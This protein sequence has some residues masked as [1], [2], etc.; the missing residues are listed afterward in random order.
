MKPIPT[1]A[2]A[3]C[4]ALAACADLSTPSASPRAADGPRLQ[5]APG[6][7]LSGS[8][9][10]SAG[11]RSYK[12]Y[13][14]TGYR[15]GTPAALVVMLHGCTQDPDQF[16]NGTEMTS[17]GEANGFLVV[18]PD[19][20][21][22]ANQNKCW[23]WF[24]PAHQSRGAGEPSLIAGIVGKLEGEY[25][26][27][28]GRVYVAG[29][30]GGAAMAVIMGVTYP[31]VF[32]AIGVASGLE[33]KAATSTG[34]AFTAMGSAGGP[35]PATQGL[36]AYNAMGS[37]RQTV[38]TIVFHGSSDFTV[39]PING[40]QVANQMQQTNDYVDDG[41]DNNSV[42]SIPDQ[43]VTGTVSGGRAWTRYVY[44]DAAG[45]PLTEK[46]IVTS[47][48]HAWSGGNSAGSYTD[49]Q[50]PKA[51][52]EMW[53]FFSAG[54]GGGDVTPPVLT[55]SP[56]GGSYAD[57]VRVMLS[58][59]EP[60]AI[61]YTTDGS[62]PR[63][64]GTRASMA[65]GGTRTFRATAMLRAYGADAAGNTS[66]TQQHTYTITTSGGGDVTA[67]TLT[68]TPAAG[69]Y[70]D[71]VLVSMSLNEAGTIWYTTDGSNP[72]T[73]G[74]RASFATSGAL[75]LRAS[76]TV[77]AYGVDAAG[78]ASAVQARAYT[79]T[80]TA[81]EQTAT[82]VSVGTEDGYAQ[83]GTSTSTTGSTFSAGSSV[84][85]GEN[86]DRAQRGVLSFNTSSLP[87]GA[88]I[89]SVEVRLFYSQTPFGSAWTTLG[90]L[91][92]DV[93]G[94]CLGASC[95]LAASDW[96]AAAAASGAVTFA[97]PAATTIGTQVTGTMATAGLGQINRTGTTQLRVRFSTHRDA[98]G[99]SDYVVFAGGDFTT[100]GYR[101]VLVVRYR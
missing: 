9:S 45:Q 24:E 15:A 93:Q 6:Q 19:Q 85:V 75:T 60:G 40:H 44:H 31:D 34:S 41:A 65:S 95:A 99:M 13:V 92:G 87:D 56:A 72:A 18:F 97:R 66:A 1:L 83:T 58:I 27:D 7:W 94:G 17:V 32:D 16:A 101:P 57:S 39:Y 22:S 25:T 51:S 64:S 43:T 78:N 12:L 11:T 26:I 53:R 96:E 90:S 98:D 33:Y 84:Y 88:V 5:T 86:L 76:A 89:T 59:D 79:V 38:R 20:P 10:N 77:S 2:L 14:P 81:P 3:G 23:N 69:T 50:G 21:S 46:W 100:A 28:A 91:V 61:W 74:T 47:M 42:D 62:D 68:I 48:G 36:A 70:A 35:N 4:L 82:F 54:S 73:S 80:S 37:F 30:S 67:P 71:S 49:P 63:T 8:F 29:L 55:V 52:Q